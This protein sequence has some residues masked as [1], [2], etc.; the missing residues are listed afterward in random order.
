M[1]AF[2]GRAPALTRCG[3]QLARSAAGAWSAPTP[4][5]PGGPKSGTRRP[6]CDGSRVKAGQLPGG[7]C[8]ALESALLSRGAGLTRADS[9]VRRAPRALEDVR[10]VLTGR[11]RV[12][13]FE[14]VFYHGRM[15]ETEAERILAARITGIAARY[16][17][18]RPLTE[19][20]EAEA[21]AS[22]TE[23]AGGRNDLLAQVAG[24]A[25]GFSEGDLGRAPAATSRTAAHQGWR[26]PGA[27]S[28][29][30][31]G[32]PPPLRSRT[33]HPLYRQPVRRVASTAGRLFDRRSQENTVLL[34]S[35]PRGRTRKGLWRTRRSEWPCGRSRG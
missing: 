4:P 9:R 23:L 18:G 26:R 16:A 5:W 1:A 8:A 24:L 7:S 10:K 21:L 25:I 30:D 15:G 17:R 3:A 13:G 14:H 34:S 31:R 19:A 11:K 32:R 28:R 20:E 27:D 33:G 12:S 35:P 22:L 6:A 29:M 2:A